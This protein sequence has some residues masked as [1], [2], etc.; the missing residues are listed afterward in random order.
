M[1]TVQFF[2]NMINIIENFLVHL[3]YTVKGK[4]DKSNK[5]ITKY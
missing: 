4:F 1:R 3:R 2:N 5:A